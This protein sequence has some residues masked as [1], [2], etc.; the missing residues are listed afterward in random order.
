[1]TTVLLVLLILL[2]VGGLPDVGYPHRYGYAPSSLAL[3]LL[4]VLIVLLATGR[5]NL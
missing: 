1:M 3:V 2:L 4:V 5:L